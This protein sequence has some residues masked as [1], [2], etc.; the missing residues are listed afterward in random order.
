MKAVAPV[1]VL[2]LVVAVQCQVLRPGFTYDVTDRRHF[3]VCD[4]GE[5]IPLPEDY[6][7]CHKAFLELIL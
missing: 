2:A 6:T 7:V 3:H 4:N 1:L 5:V